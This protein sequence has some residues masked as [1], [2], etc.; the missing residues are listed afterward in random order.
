MH[1]F[2]HSGRRVCAIFA[3]TIHG[4]CK[5]WYTAC[6]MMVWHI[7]FKGDIPS[8]WFFAF[9]FFWVTI[10]MYAT[11]FFY[12]LLLIDFEISTIYKVM[13]I[14]RSP[15]GNHTCEWSENSFLSETECVVYLFFF[16]FWDKIFQCVSLRSLL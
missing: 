8:F 11:S 7:C 1:L 6:L 15:D 16:F 5:S 12:F 10:K 4:S 3:C 9:F 14:I 13:G 2:P